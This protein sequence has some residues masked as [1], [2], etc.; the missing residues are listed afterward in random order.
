MRLIGILLI[1]TFLLT[2]GIS[3]ASAS[4]SAD[5]V[6]IG[7]NYVDLLDA[8]TSTSLTLTE[9]GVAGVYDRANVILHDAIRYSHN[10]TFRK[11]ITATA[12][13]TSGGASDLTLKATVDGSEEAVI[14]DAGAPQ[15]DVPVWTNIDAGGYVKDITWT[16]SGT[17][18]GTASSANSSRQYVWQVTFTSSDN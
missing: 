5:V 9:S 12:S 11:K 18:F 16:A 14:V 15:T 2:L 8:P 1:G 7:V 17:S 3:G 4:T 13:L 6:S 10:S